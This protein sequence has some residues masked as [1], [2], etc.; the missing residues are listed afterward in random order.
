[1]LIAPVI[2]F[3][4]GLVAIVWLW[5]ILAGWTDVANGIATMAIGAAVCAVRRRTWLI[6]WPG[7]RP[8]NGAR[9]IF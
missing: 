9:A 5:G 4:F 7:S 2:I 3:G 8:G 1:M 6:E